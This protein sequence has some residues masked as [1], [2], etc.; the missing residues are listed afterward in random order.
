MRSDRQ[1]TEPS[2]WQAGM[3]EINRRS[4]GMYG[5]IP[6]I[7]HRARITGDMD[8]PRAHLDIST[9]AHHHHP[10]MVDGDRLLLHG[11]G[12]TAQVLDFP[13]DLLLLSRGIILGEVPS[14]T[15]MARGPMVRRPYTSSTPE[16]LDLPYND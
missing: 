5:P 6:I 14:T 2:L 8:R 15:D 4:E 16:E 3:M 12:H 13:L 7:P 9:E 10:F 1:E 11:I